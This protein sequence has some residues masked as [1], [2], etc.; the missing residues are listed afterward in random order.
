VGVGVGAGAGVA[1]GE[2]PAPGVVAAA[3]PWRPGSES[4]LGV[5]ADDG[6]VLGLLATPP[7]GTGGRE[8]PAWFRWCCFFLG[9][10][11]RDS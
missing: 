2:P 1:A 9:W 10:N 3:A 5:E 4:A 6:G 11:K 8:T 7:S